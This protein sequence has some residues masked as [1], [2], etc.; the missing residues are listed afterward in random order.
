MSEMREWK[1]SKGSRLGG[2]AG[3]LRQ[4]SDLDTFSFPLPE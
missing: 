2:L 3:E 4:D 1:E